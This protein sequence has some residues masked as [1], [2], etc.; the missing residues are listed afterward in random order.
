ML[1]ENRTAI[2][3]GGSGAIGS[4]VARAYAREGAEAHL[5]ARRRE[6][7]EEVAHWI[8]D[9]R[10]RD[11]PLR[12]RRRRLTPCAGS[13]WSLPVSRG[14]A[15]GSSGDV[16]DLRGRP[17]PLDAEDLLPLPGGVPVGDPRRRG[18]PQEDVAAHTGS[19]PDPAKGVQVD[20][21]VVPGPFAGVVDPSRVARDRSP[22][23][24]PRHRAP[25]GHAHPDNGRQPQ[26]AERVP[27]R[28][29]E[30]QLTQTDPPTH[31]EACG[32]PLQTGMVGIDEADIGN[33]PALPSTTVVE[34][35]CP[36]QE[37]SANKPSARGDG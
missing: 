14:R 25:H 28:M 12:R 19:L 36:N 29:T 21:Q 11:Q 23:V 4:A 20:D 26:R 24:D 33:E 7:L 15:A 35:F 5:T 1:L 34:A 17:L 2:I 32:T 6:P 13:R 18:L 8:D 37:C 27:A 10:H 3:H 30:D 9:D 31:C 22:P 16:L